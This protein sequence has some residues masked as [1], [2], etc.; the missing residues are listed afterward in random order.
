[1]EDIVMLILTV[2]AVWIAVTL[3]QIKHVLRRTM[4]NINETLAGINTRLDE[5]TTELLALIGTLTNEQLTPEGRAALDAIKTKVD[6][7]ADVVP[8]V[9]PQP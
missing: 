8:G 4:A 3:N 9:P 6:A 2:S 7:L 5:A 1:M